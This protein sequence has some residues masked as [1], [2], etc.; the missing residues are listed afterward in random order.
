MVTLRNWLN[1]SSQ[2]HEN[3]AWN[4]KGSIWIFLKKFLVDS[5]FYK[6]LSTYFS[7]HWE[8]YFLPFTISYGVS[9]LDFEG[10]R[11]SSEKGAQLSWDT[12]LQSKQEAVEKAGHHLPDLGSCPFLPPPFFIMGYHVFS[13]QKKARTNFILI[14]EL[15]LL[16]VLKTW[17]TW[18]NAWWILRHHSV[19]LQ[20]T[21][22]LVRVH[23]HHLQSRDLWTSSVFPSKE[24]PF[25]HHPHETPSKVK[26]DSNDLCV[27]EG[28]QSLPLIS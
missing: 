7:R 25:F 9:M 24:H 23:N 1:L 8:Q 5:S 11:S 18:R 15:L 21:T 14:K 2:F 3:P 27:T 4:L 13:V 12:V 17:K 19:V 28:Y 22:I 6:W 16:G 26:M 10:W 20:H